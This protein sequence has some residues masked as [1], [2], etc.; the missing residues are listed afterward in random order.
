[1]K[2]HSAV[3]AGPAALATMFAAIG[4]AACSSAAPTPKS[5]SV[6]A[7]TAMGGADKLRSI[8]T[9]TM[10]SGSGSRTR[11]QQ[12]VHVGDPEVPGTLKNVVEIIDLA[13]GRASLDYELTSGEFTQHRHEVLTSRG[14]KPVGLD[15]V[16]MRPVVATS[17]GGLFSWGTQNSPEV[18]L[19]RNLVSI[20]LAAADSASD[21]R[22]G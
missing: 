6:D 7:L 10:K 2:S 13:G 16:G 4:I 17:P 11:L 8:Q 18:S 3:L 5:L 20:L 12:T 14:G 22:G 19:R 9:I 15:Y 1:M 21:A